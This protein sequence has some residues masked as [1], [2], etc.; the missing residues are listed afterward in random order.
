MYAWTENSLYEIDYEGERFRR[1]DGV[2]P[3][4]ALLSEDGEWHDGY[5]VP[6]PGPEFRVGC[7]LVLIYKTVAGRRTVTSPIRKL[8]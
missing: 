4:T 3:P 7:R 5:T 6:I 8:L 2:S 1:L